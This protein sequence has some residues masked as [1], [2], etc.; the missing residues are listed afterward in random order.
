MVV[1][2]AG[3]RLYYKHRYAEAHE[4]M[5][6][7]LTSIAEL[8]SE[9]IRNWIHERRGD[10][11]V[12]RYS[13]AMQDALSRPANTVLPPQISQIVSI[14]RQVYNYSAIIVTDRAGKVQ[15]TVPD[16]FTV[17][18]SAIAEHVQLALNSRKVEISF[19]TQ[20]RPDEPRYFGV[21]CP[22]FREGETDGAPIGTVLLLEDPHTFLYPTIQ[23]WPVALRTAKSFLVLRKD[24]HVIGLNDSLA[25][26]NEASGGQTSGPRTE[27]RPA[28]PFGA[29]IAGD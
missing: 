7:S 29:G 20:M 3:G 14:F 1:L 11:E 12:A 4:A 13:R 2:A 24:G 6:Q 15:L 16:D 18:V 23:R 17:S 10:A 25:S 26:A 5:Q 27:I 9:D 8:K 28:Q 21:S 22:I 19:L